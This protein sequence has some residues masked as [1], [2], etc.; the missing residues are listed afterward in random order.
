MSINART[1]ADRTAAVLGQAAD[2]VAGGAGGGLQVRRA[3]GER[4]GSGGGLD[5]HLS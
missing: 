1:P 2:V 4:A 3:V 5:A